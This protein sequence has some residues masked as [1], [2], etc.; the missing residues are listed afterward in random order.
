MCNV[1]CYL[2]LNITILILDK[3]HLL[4]NACKQCG[5][6]TVMFRITNTTAPIR[7]VK[8]ASAKSILLIMFIEVMHKGLVKTCRLLG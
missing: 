7:P 8:N 5:Y 2:L 4:S 3:L 6:V 1:K